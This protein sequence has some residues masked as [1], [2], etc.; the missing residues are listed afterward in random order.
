MTHVTAL[1]FATAIT[2]LLI[3]IGASRAS[4]GAATTTQSGSADTSWVLF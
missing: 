2:L 4:G 3:A 1:V